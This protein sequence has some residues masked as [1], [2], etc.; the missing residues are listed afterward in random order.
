[1]DD[2]QGTVQLVGAGV[3]VL[4]SLAHLLGNEDGVLLGEPWQAQR[5]GATDDFGE[6]LAAHVLHRQVVVP[7]HF[8][9]VED[10]GNVAVAEGDGDSRLVDEHPD[11]VALSGEGGEDFL[12]HHCLGDSRR[13]HLPRPVELRHSSHSKAL[14]KLVAAKREGRFRHGAKA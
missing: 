14:Q 8:A 1:V 5:M 10:L 11:K 3:G 2:V 9:E 12:H 13:R 6:W 7:V 4:Q